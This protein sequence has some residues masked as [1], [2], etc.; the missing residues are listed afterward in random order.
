MLNPDFN[1]VYW[2]GGFFALTIIIFFARK[3]WG[4]LGH[5]WEILKLVFKNKF[6]W[7][8]NI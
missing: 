8:F 3:Y 5:I 6:R 1:F 7:L 2:I 4:I